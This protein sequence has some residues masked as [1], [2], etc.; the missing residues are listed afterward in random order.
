[1]LVETIRDVIG[2]GGRTRTL[3]RSMWRGLA[4]RHKRNGVRPRQL[5]GRV[6]LTRVCRFCFAIGSG[7]VPWLPPH[8][9]R[10]PRRKKPR[11]SDYNC[12]A[13]RNYAGLHR[14][15]QPP[16]C[17]ELTPADKHERTYAVKTIPIGQQGTSSMGG[18]QPLC[19]LGQLLRQRITQGL[20]AFLVGWSLRSAARISRR[21]ICVN[22]R[23]P[24]LRLLM[25]A[26]ITRIPARRY[27][28]TVQG[29][30]PTPGDRHRPPKAPTGGLRAHS[31]AGP[32]L[33]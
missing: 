33:H 1:M 22:T 11:S 21:S 6:T 8:I 9:I 20:S 32:R 4:V 26:A 7:G 3:D 17:A 30:L 24:T 23:I 18:V 28:R 19:V 10:R 5:T 31:P 13:Y 25:R 2:R 29:P 16:R 27:P 12:R 15:I 14:M